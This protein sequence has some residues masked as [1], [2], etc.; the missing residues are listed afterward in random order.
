MAVSRSFTRLGRHTVALRITDNGVPAQHAMA[1]LTVDAGGNR[2]PSAHAGG[3]YVVSVDGSVTLDASGSFDPDENSGDRIVHYAWDLNGDGFFNDAFGIAPTLSADFFAVLGL[4]GPAHP[5]TGEPSN[6]IHLKVTD[7]FGV[8]DTAASDI[9]IYQDEPMALF[10]MTPDP[11]AADIEITFDA[12]PSMHG[13]PDRR[14]ILYE[15]D[16]NHDRSH[17]KPAAEGSIV[18][19][20]FSADQPGEIIVALR[21]TD[22]GSPAGQDIYTR[23]VLSQDDGRLPMVRTL[24]VSVTSSSSAAV[25]GA[26]LFDGGSAIQDRGVVLSA[27]PDF[28][29]EKSIPATDGATAA[30]GFSAFLTGLDPGTTYYAKAWA[31]NDTGRG[32]GRII[33]FT[34]PRES[35]AGDINGDDQVDLRDLIR[36]LQIMSGMWVDNID[37]G[38]DVNGD[39]RIG[40]EEMIFTTQKISGSQGR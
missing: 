4:A 25:H 30:N 13:H 35:V 14:I 3:P 16:F 32:Y 10:T 20:T 24:L 21:V 22:D 29:S 36:A 40:P 12:F 5:D 28:F 26:L 6:R 23:A 2:A 17:F 31:E 9:T 19:H 39:G 18:T 11:A 7:S 34:T 38:A 8:S 33:S 15:W 27:D 37:K 1:V